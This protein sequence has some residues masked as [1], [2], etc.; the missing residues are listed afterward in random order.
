MD[1]RPKSRSERENSGFFLNT[2][3][4]LPGQDYVRTFPILAKALLNDGDDKTSALPRSRHSLRGFLLGTGWG[5]AVAM[6]LIAAF[7]ILFG[8]LW[9]VLI[10]CGESCDLYDAQFLQGAMWFSWGIFFDPGTHTALSALHALPQ[11]FHGVFFSICG[12]GFNLVVLGIVVE[13]CRSQVLN[14]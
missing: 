7:L 11:K 14:I 5:Q 2:G 3:D 4:M 13:L 9:W 1:D 10:G 8:A 12:L 6:F